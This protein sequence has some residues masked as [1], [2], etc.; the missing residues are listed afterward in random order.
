MFHA[1]NILVPVFAEVPDEHVT[2]VSVKIID[3][4]GN[5]CCRIDVGVSVTIVKFACNMVRLVLKIVY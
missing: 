5:I 3:V 4:Y 2:R 1:R